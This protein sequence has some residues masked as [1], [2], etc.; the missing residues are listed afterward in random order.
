MPWY[1]GTAPSSS[2]CS[3]S[4]G[5]LIRSAKKSAEFS[6]YR[7]RFSHSDPPM[8]LCVFSYWNC[9]AT[10]DSQRMPP[11][12]L[13]MFATGAP[14]HRRREHVGLR[15]QVRRAVAAPRVAVQ[16]ELLRVG[17]AHVHQLLHAGHQALQHRLPGWPTVKTMSGRK[18]A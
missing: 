9:R 11:Y 10:P 6:M 1:H 12:A 2:P 3:M 7:S 17:H 8:R 18:I 4:S 5:V 16:A 13:V 15:H 14:G